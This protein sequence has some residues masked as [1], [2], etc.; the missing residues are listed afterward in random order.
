MSQNTLIIATESYG[1]MG[2]YVASIVNSF[3]EDDD[4]VFLLVEGNDHYYSK[5]I[6]QEMLRKTTIIYSSGLSRSKAIWNLINKTQY[7]F[8][9][10]IKSYCTENKFREVHILSS[11]L[12]VKLFDWLNKNFKV[13]FTVHDLTPHEVTGPLYKKWLNK[14]RY[15][16]YFRIISRSHYLTT[17]SLVQFTELKKRYPTQE[18][19]YF[20]FPTLV[21]ENIASGKNVPPELKNTDQYLLF[22]GRIEAYKGVENLI[23]AFNESNLPQNLK[24]IIAGKGLLDKNLLSD[25]IIHINRFIKDNEIAELYRRA[26][27]VVYPYISAT[28]SGVLSIATYF[29]TP[30]LLS[31]LPFFREI[32]GNDYQ[33]FFIPSNI[34]SITKTIEKFF[35]NPEEFNSVNKHKEIYNRIYKKEVMR[36]QLL[37]IY[38]SVSLI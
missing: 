31:N 37:N 26:K 20:S 8:S 12:D 21:T 13:I 24:L 35:K 34:L 30:I 14:L 27:C 19:Y 16:N 15:K 29:D 3:T 18:S 32:M 1:G 2:P 25:N 5:N 4:V 6:R 11:F 38:K 7:S 36:E 28:Q 23:L 17:N 10:D 22:F 33:G 9:K